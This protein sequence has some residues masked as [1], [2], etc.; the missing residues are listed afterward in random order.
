MT[1]MDKLY[2][3]WLLTNPKGTK[4][5]FVTDLVLKTIND[6]RLKRKKA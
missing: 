4:I 2:E 6:I 5:E 3:E 1:K